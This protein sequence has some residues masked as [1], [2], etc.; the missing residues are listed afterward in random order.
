MKKARKR[1]KVVFVGIKINQ[2]DTSVTP[3]IL[4]SYPSNNNNAHND[5]YSL[6]AECDDKPQLSHMNSETNNKTH[7]P[8]TNNDSI[9]SGHK[10]T[11]AHSIHVS[12][13]TSAK[14][15]SDQPIPYILD[16]L[17]KTL[18]SKIEQKK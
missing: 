14:Q 6:N 2:S 3:S 15:L 8:L 10:Q 17:E 16:S 11:R 7:I 9:G 12:I 1:K 4:P 18:Q 13:P 5:V